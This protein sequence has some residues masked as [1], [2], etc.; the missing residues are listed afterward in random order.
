MTP[1]QLLRAYHA[2]HPGA[3]ARAFAD[4]RGEDGRSTYQILAALPAPGDAVLDL[5]CGDGLLLELLLERGCRDLVGVDM[6]PEELA[7]AAARPA[8]AGVRLV[9]AR[10][11]ALPLP[12]A[13]VDWA[14]SHMA[15]MLMSEVEAVVAE[16]A[17][18]LR[19]GGRFVAVVGGGPAEEADGFA[20]FLRLYQLE[21]DALA[22][23]PPPIG[24]RRTREAD[25][26]ASLFHPG[27]GFA[28][29]VEETA[30]TVRHDAAAERVWDILASIY[31]MLLVPPERRAAMRERFLAE[32]PAGD[33][34]LV[35]C[36]LRY[37]LLAARRAP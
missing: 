4:G 2:Q 16:L 1:D 17:R 13:S 34:G 32:A 15:F 5:G 10:A 37:R 23:K 8:L 9:E 21:H 18:V 27:T 24:D 29:G 11:D 31:G 26:L 6:S 7:A 30:L 28:A 14:L 3:T 25:G 36:A 12:A 22:E 33:G 20:R 19:P 35:P